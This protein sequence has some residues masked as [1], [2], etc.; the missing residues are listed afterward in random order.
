M[1]IQ[2]LQLLLHLIIWYK[3]KESFNMN[4]SLELREKICNIINEYINIPL[5][6]KYFIMKDITNEIY[7]FLLLDNINLQQEEIKK[8]SVEIE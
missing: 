8:D 4:I 1:T 2:M 3:K 6:T 7:E 5:D